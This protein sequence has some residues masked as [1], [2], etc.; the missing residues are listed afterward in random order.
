[1]SRLEIRGARA[2]YGQVEA[3]HGVDLTIPD[4]TTVA[5]IGRNASGKSTL[6]RCIAG[7]VPLRGGSMRWGGDDL[8][9]ASAY[10][11]ASMGIVLVPEQRNVFPGLTVREN[12]QLFARGTPLDPA[13]ATFPELEPLAERLAGTLSGGERQMVALSHALLRPAHLLLFDEV[14]RGLAPAI[15]GRFYDRIVALTAPGRTNVIVEQYLDDALRVAD[16]VYLLRRGEVAFAGEPSELR[17]TGAVVA[18]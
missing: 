16:L 11:R 5:I 12:L 2:G 14:S 7:L 4:G 6:L 3:L 13:F 10:E 1:M 15:V 9:K 8:A 17:D 18:Q